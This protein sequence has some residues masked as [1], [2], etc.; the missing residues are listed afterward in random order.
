MSKVIQKDQTYIVEGFIIKN[1]VTSLY[2]HN[3][4]NSTISAPL[5]IY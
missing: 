3:E 4:P 2:V 5:S 1:N